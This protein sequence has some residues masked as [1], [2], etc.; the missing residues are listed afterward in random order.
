MHLFASAL[1]WPT[2]VQRSLFDPPCE[3][4]EAVAEV[5]RAVNNRVGRFSLRSGATLPLADVYRD[6]AQS[7]DICDVH[8]KTCF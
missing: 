8:G 7:Y 5:K 6:E 2:F 1:E 3:R 4:A